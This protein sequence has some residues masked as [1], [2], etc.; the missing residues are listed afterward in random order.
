MKII[1][2]NMAEVIDD[3]VDGI[4]KLG[5]KF[6]AIHI[7]KKLKVSPQLAK[8]QINLLLHRLLDTNDDTDCVVWYRYLVAAGNEFYDFKSEVLKYDDASRCGLVWT[9]NF[10]AYR[11]RTCGVTPCMSICS[12]CFHNSDHTGHDFNMFRSHAGGACD[13][14]DVHAMRHT[15]FCSNHVPGKRSVQKPPA[16]LLA[17]AELVVPRI[18]YHFVLRLRKLCQP[19]RNGSYKLTEVMK[20]QY[21]QVSQLLDDLSKMGGAMK[22]VICQSLCNPEI[23]KI[24]SST[25][26]LAV[27][28]N[29]DKKKFKE[30]SIDEYYA[31]LLTLPTPSIPE[32][33]QDC[34]GLSQ[35]LVH[36]SF[37]QEIMFWMVKYEFPEKIITFLLSLLTDMEYKKPFTDAFVMHYSRICMSLVRSPEVIPDRVVHISVQVLSNEVL[38]THVVKNLQLFHIMILSIQ[39]MVRSSLTDCKI[40][41]EYGTNVNF[42]Q[43]VSCS[44]QVIRNHSYWPII[45]DLTNLMSHKPCVDVFFASPDLIRMWTSLLL[46]FTGINLNE[47]EHEQHLEFSPH[48]YAAF[49]A[50]VEACAAPMWQLVSHCKTSETIE[51]SKMMISVCAEEIQDWF[52]ALNLNSAPSPMQFSFHL[53]LLRHLALFISFAV[54]KQSQVL[55]PLLP[56]TDGYM[57][58]LMMFPLQIQ[59]C[60]Y[61]I[62]AGMWIRNG[63][64]IKAQAMTYSQCHFCSSMLDLDIFLLQLCT[65]KLKS[66]VVIT[67]ILERYHVLDYLSL[68]PRHTNTFLKK[69]GQ[70]MVM[71]EGALYLLLAVINTRVH[72]GMSNYELLKSE[73]IAMLCM[74][75][76]THSQLLDQI[77][78]RS[79]VLSISDM[80][81][82]ILKEVADFKDPTQLSGGNFRQGQYVLKPELWMSEFDPIMVQMRSMQRKDY[83]AALDNYTAIMK[84][85]GKHIG[86][87]VLWPAYQPLKDINQEFKPVQQLLHSRTLHAALFLVL[88]KA[89]NEKDVSEP[90]MYQCIALISLALQCQP[91]DITQVE[92]G[93]TCNDME[94]SDWFPY[95]NMLKNISYTIKTIEL[96]RKEKTDSSNPFRALLKDLHA[97]NSTFPVEPPVQAAFAGNLGPDLDD[98]HMEMAD[99][100]DIDDEEDDEEEE[101]FFDAI[102]NA[103]D[104]IEMTG[105]IEIPPQ[106]TAYDEEEKAPIPSA[107]DTAKCTSVD[108]NESMLSL[109][110]KL[111][112]KLSND[113]VYKRQATGSTDPKADS[114]CDPK[115]GSGP[116]YI[117]KLLDRL[118]EL[119][120]ECADRLQV[121]PKKRQE[122]DNVDAVSERKRKALE[123]QQHLLAKFASQQKQ[124]LEENPQ[125][126]VE[127]AK[128]IESVSMETD[129]VSSLEEQIECVICTQPIPASEDNPLG[130]VVLVQTTNVLNH[131]SVV[132]DALEHEAGCSN[133]VIRKPTKTSH[134][135]NQQKKVILT[136]FFKEESSYFAASLG[137]SS[138]DVHIQT[139]GHFLHLQCHAN[140]VKSLRLSRHN[141]IQQGEYLC[142][143][144]RQL[145]NSFLPCS[146]QSL[147]DDPDGSQVDSTRELDDH[148]IRQQIEGSFR[149]DFKLNILP[150]SVRNFLMQILKPKE[151]LERI[152]GVAL[153]NTVRTNLEL[154]LINRNGCLVS[155][156]PCPVPKRSCVGM[157]LHGIRAQY[158]STLRSKLQEL[159][160]LLL[161]GTPDG[162][163][164]PPALLRNPVNLLLQLIVSIRLPLSIHHFQYI[165]KVVWRLT[166][167]QILTALSCRF[168]QE[169]RLAWKEKPK[170]M[171]FGGC[172]VEK[173]LSSVI[174]YFIRG[175]L[176]QEGAHM[177]VEITSTVW[178]RGSILNEVEQGSMNFIQIASLLQ[179][180][181]YRVDLPASKEGESEFDTLLSYLKL[182][183]VVRNDDV[184]TSDL[185]TILKWCT[186]LDNVAIRS[187]SQTQQLLALNHANY[188]VPHLIQ[189]PHDFSKLFQHYSKQKCNLCYA[190]LKSPALCLVCGNLISLNA[191]C[192]KLR[193]K[194]EGGLHASV[195]GS[196]TA[197]YLSIDSSNIM[198]YRGNRSCTWSSVYLDH[199][200]EEDSGLKRGKPL[201]LN[202]ARYSFLENLWRNHT[203]DHN[204]KRL[205]Q[206]NLY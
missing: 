196:G 125:I 69:E 143:M 188:S 10:V 168:T 123:R 94:L 43:V 122:E 118:A 75:E 192:C 167:T 22:H 166:C 153:I 179:H 164:S 90:V 134:V 175:K 201:I 158:Q 171:G 120:K 176:Y 113:K 131:R 206:M 56:N 127:S 81:E 198:I 108:I 71:L 157:L 8:R 178:T 182:T 78:E 184:N 85:S 203:L 100:D 34:P 114:G 47:R 98:I 14:G 92:V 154:D 65:C 149:K 3:E 52:D 163:D 104:I 156:Q 106:A 67:T 103:M 180:Y 70:E 193:P 202:E 29:D 99:N 155:K 172:P 169:E 68:N 165:A 76:K 57:L 101:E 199:Y 35:I 46:T 2:T 79:E 72:L 105:V 185:A 83:Q 16:H 139:C 74:K 135:I 54:N 115:A 6:A 170:R 39:E 86:S 48:Y 32:I 146:K 186:E 77:P 66:D 45:S 181:L 73:V 27:L 200:G 80:F 13:C 96:T 136:Q 130:A 129:P 89:V 25:E 7:D 33:I 44:N 162:S 55:Q 91:N 61:E 160:E 1:T 124:F 4:A 38:A 205:I 137:C 12:D 37:L 128:Q 147:Q 11:C 140:Y 177:D 132:G 17:M 194:N 161:K 64:Q 190:A 145:A 51:F 111:Y 5:P 191:T 28:P 142:P 95:N 24:L 23:Y 152:N 116:Y 20:E 31:A 18:V 189:L 93:D 138:S 195:C 107:T 102:Q 150:D 42:H 173:I 187:V 133:D 62:F 58:Q 110:V 148:R 63:L 36:T 88:H 82:D 9:A 97:E 126:S 112:S 197:I 15:G 109:L 41:D 26:D 144:C 30:S 59:V 174:G 21:T 151:F 19:E 50:E 49:T 53:P 119:S 60:L 121:H 84:Q 183:N 117:G 141:L 40:K 87:D 159:W 204:C